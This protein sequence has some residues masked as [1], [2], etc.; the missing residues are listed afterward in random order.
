MR[1]VSTREGA[2]RVA[3]FFTGAKHAGENIAELLEKR[4]AELPKLIQMCDALATNTSVEFETIV[5]ACVAH[6]RR[7]F[8]EVAESFPA[9][10]R[11]VLETLRDV[12]K[13]DALAKERGMTPDERLRFHQPE[14]GPLMDGLE[15]CMREQFEHR[16][17]EPN[18]RLGDAIRYMQKRDLP[19][20]ARCQCWS[21]VG[22]STPS[23]YNPAGPAQLHPSKFRPKQFI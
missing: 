3:L 23:L 6:G 12:Y 18:S 22:F 14:S 9:E 8:V 1:P 2:H 21:I 16:K 11:F 7:H 10:G 19:S 13:N 17:V 20:A 15:Q 4:D 5:A